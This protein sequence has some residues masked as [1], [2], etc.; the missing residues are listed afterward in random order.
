MYLKKGTHSVPFEVLLSNALSE[1]IECGLG[2]VR[3]KLL[4]RVNVKPWS[5]LFGSYLK[6]YCPVVLVRLPPTDT[7]RCITQTHVLADDQLNIVIDSAHITPGSNLSLSV[8]FSKPGFSID[9]LVVK[10]IERQKFRAP[11]K[12]TTRILHHEITLTSSDPHIVDRDEIRAVY[13]IPDKQTLQIHP[14]TANRNI[15]VRHWI[16]VSLR[17]LLPGQTSTPKEILMDAPITVLESPIDDYITLPVYEQTEQ[18]DTTYYTPEIEFSVVAPASC[19]S[20]SWLKRIQKRYLSKEDAAPP[21]YS[22]ISD[23][24]V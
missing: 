19:S 8:L 17:L 11:S 1:S 22:A 2:R 13:V 14:S 9:Q 3:Y 15:R 7:P 16:Q 4:C 18:T 21:K 5:T 20:S 6:A 24:F 10:L 12:H 23:S